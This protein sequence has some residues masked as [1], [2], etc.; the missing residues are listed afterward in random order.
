MIV[1]TGMPMTIVMG[2]PMTVCTGMSTIGKHAS[3]APKRAF[4][5]PNGPFFGA[6]GVP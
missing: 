5:G 3:R 4:R 2:V 1:A 6:P